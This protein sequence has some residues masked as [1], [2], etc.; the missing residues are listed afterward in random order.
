MFA[1]MAD[2]PNGLENLRLSMMGG[3]GAALPATDLLPAADARLEPTPPPVVGFEPTTYS[4]SPELLKRWNALNSAGASA[5]PDMAVIK[6]Q[7]D[8]GK[9]DQ[10][11]VSMDQVQAMLAQAKAVAPKTVVAQKGTVP[12]PVKAAAPSKTNAL[13]I[14]GGLLAVG[15]VGAALI[16]ASGNKSDEGDE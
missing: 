7:I 16:K 9:F 5:L 4:G 15:I 13:W 1:A 2:A 3:L 11:A 14:I 8:D 12:P 10:A 6:Q